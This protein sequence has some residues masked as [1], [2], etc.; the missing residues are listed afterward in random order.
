MPSRITLDVDLFGLV[1]RGRAFHTPHPTHRHDAGCACAGADCVGGELGEFRPSW[2]I[3]GRIGGM[4]DIIER[5]NRLNGVMFSTIE[6]ALIA[7]LVGAFATYFL[8]QYRWALAFAAWGITFNCLPVVVLGS[9]ELSRRKRT[10]ER[11]GSKSHTNLIGSGSL[12]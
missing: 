9:Q 8:F 5:H 1:A 4:R 6:F 12:E 11:I 10:G 2:R 3:R 7:V